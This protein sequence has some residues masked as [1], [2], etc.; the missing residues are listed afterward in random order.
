MCAPGLRQHFIGIVLRENAF[1]ARLYLIAEQITARFTTKQP[2]LYPI[3]RAQQEDLTKM[4]GADYEKFKAIRN[5][6]DPVGLFENTL[7]R[8]LFPR[9]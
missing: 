2:R 9:T 8:N 7:I 3:W 1:G 4:Y 5:E 6:L